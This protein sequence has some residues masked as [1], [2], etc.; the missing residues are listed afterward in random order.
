MIIIIIFIFIKYTDILDLCL[1]EIIF[2]LP[3]DLV[4]EYVH[5]KLQTYLL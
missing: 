4:V 3:F 2:S 5:P 1:Y